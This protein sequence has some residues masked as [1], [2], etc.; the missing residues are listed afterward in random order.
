MVHV[1][2]LQLFDS[3]LYWAQ[4]TV[5]SYIRNRA[6]AHNEEGRACIFTSWCYQ[7]ARNPSQGSENTPFL[8]PPS[9]VRNLAC[10]CAK[11]LQN[12]YMAVTLVVGI[13][14][15][16]GDMLAL[17]PVCAACILVIATPLWMW[18]RFVIN[19]AAAFPLCFIYRACCQYS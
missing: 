10:D 18:V 12:C 11:M 9:H 5:C 4:Q 17:F 2:R 16:E 8:R 6:W 1:T 13:F 15:G 7:V 14:S 3:F 19:K